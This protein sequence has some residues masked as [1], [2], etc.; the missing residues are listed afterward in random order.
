MLAH[1]R[2]FGPLTVQRPFYPEGGA[3]HL[4]L[5]HPPGGVVGGDRLEI[6]V[7][8]R[9]GAHALIT[10]P[11]AAKFYR[12]AGP[13]ALQHQRLVVEDGGVLEWFPHENILFPGAM[14]GN[15]M[16]VKLSGDA[17]FLG[18]EIQSLGRPVIGERF[19]SGSAD[20]RLDVSREGRPLL[21]E[22]LRIRGNSDLDGPSGLRG[23]AVAASFVASRAGPEDVEAAREGL[24]MP[25]G[26][27]FAMSLVEDLLVARCLAG[28]VEPVNRIFLALWGILRPR[29]LGREACAPRIWAT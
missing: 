25:T 23:F 1:K 15:R 6:D 14:L 29:L 20:L 9:S 19:D 11:G 22:R 27:P 2:Q 24:E 17:R 18:W 4:Y 7:Q 5:L 12:S 16:Q 8:V 28:S 13:W 10:T 3:C 21:S 26:H